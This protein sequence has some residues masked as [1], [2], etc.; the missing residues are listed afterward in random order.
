MLREKCVGSKCYRNFLAKAQM[1][2]HLRRQPQG[3]GSF[4]DLLK[5][6]WSQ[7]DCWGC[8]GKGPCSWCPTVSVSLDLLGTPSPLARPLTAPRHPPAFPTRLQSNFSL[9]YT[10]LIY[11]HFGQKDGSSELGLWGAMSR[12]SRSWLVLY[13]FCQRSW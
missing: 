3:N 13:L 7:Q 1:P 4:D 11:V 9:Q 2:L 8:L 12:P 5:Y 6:C 10:T